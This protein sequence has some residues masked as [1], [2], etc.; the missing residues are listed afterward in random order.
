M[1]Q[2]GCFGLFIISTLE[3]CSPYKLSGRHPSALFT[4]RG[5]DGVIACVTSERTSERLACSAAVY[6]YQTAVRTI[7]TKVNECRA[8]IMCLVYVMDRQA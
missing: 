5:N 4:R 6:H 1:E 3:P 7:N 2:Y 8:S